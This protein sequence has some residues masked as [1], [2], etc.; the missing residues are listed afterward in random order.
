MSVAPTL[1]PSHSEWGQCLGGNNVVEAQ[2]DSLGPLFLR[3][4]GAG[5][6]PT[7]SA[8]VADLVEIASGRGS[9]G[10]EPITGWCRSQSG[11]IVPNRPAQA[12]FLR[13]LLAGDDEVAECATAVTTALKRVG[14]H[15]SMADTSMGETPEPGIAVWLSSPVDEIQIRSICSEVARLS[16]SKG[17]FAAFP[18][19]H[20]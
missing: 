3:G 16:P 5:G 14:V 2:C 1:V 11:T 7:A 6:R 15:G 8:I 18:I 4:L 13:W 20:V 19:L 10:P 12:Y 17:A 9:V